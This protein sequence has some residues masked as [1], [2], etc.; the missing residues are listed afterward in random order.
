[1]AIF[2]KKYDPEKIPVDSPE[3]DP[4]KE[5]QAFLDTLVGMMGKEPSQKGDQEIL[6]AL[7]LLESLGDVGVMA[8][9]VDAATIYLKEGR[10]FYNP[11]KAMDLLKGEVEKDNPYAQ[12]MMGMIMLE[13]N[14]VTEKDPVMAKFYLEKSA[15]AGFEPSIEEVESRWR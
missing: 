4:Q 1:M 5:Y 14:E 9:K 6:Y 8:A 15:E 2:G 3:F 12:Y 11:Q 7:E 10:S 13:G